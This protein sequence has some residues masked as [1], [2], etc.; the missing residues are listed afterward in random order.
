MSEKVHN[1]VLIGE[2]GN[3]KSSLGNF[4]LGSS[5]FEV[6]DDF[7]SCTKDT[8]QKISKIDPEIGVV[9]TP[10]LQDSNGEDKQNYDKMLKIFEDVK[11]LH[12]IVVVLNFSNPRLTSSIQ[13]MLKFLCNV[14]PK[15]F[16]LH[17]GI[18]F[19]HYEHSYQ[20]KVYKK[21]N[22][23]P[24]ESFDKY[25]N[26]VIRLIEKYTGE[27]ALKRPPVYFLD[28]LIEDEYSKKQL[29]N[30]IAFAKFLKPI[31]N[32]RTDCEL[33]IKSK[34]P[35]YETRV[36]EKVEGNL[37]V[38]YYKKFKRMKY[39]DYNDNVTYSDW[40]HVDTQTSSRSLPVRTEVVYKE[41]ESDD[42]KS[43]DSKSKDSKSKDSDKD[44]EGSGGDT[45]IQDLISTVA[46]SLVGNFLYKNK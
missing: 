18:V 26:E 2:T 11:N 22:K 6:S 1:I 12:F 19:T 21:K 33:G 4:I 25:I 24:Q 13:F 40:E 30:L 43:D 20:L 41:K 15:N 32:I 3:G 28:S 27:K 46:L 37:I 9:D 17:V 39:T 34:E 23:D 31:E 35:V 14:F 45:L 42:S 8:I 29:N 44:N 7:N 10:G 16:S 5:E 36:E 38:T